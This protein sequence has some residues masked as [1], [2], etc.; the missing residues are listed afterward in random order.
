MPDKKLTD[1]ENKDLVEHRFKAHCE[2]CT[3]KPDCCDICY[4]TNILQ[5]TEAFDRLQK[6]NERLKKGWKADVI[7]TANIKAEAYKEF[8]ERLKH[9][10]INIGV[11]DSIVSTYAI[12]NLLKELVGDN[13]G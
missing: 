6:E 10:A 7:E 8:A 5:L 12:D 9:K 1:K 3:L 11:K 2:K 13:N 4:F